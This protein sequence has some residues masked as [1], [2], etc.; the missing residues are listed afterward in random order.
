MR[1]EFTARNVLDADDRAVGVGAQDNLA[2]FLFAL[3]TPL[4]AHSVGEFLP[5]RDRLGAHGTGGVHGILG[6]DRVNNFRDGDIELGQLIR[7]NPQAHGV[8]AGAENGDAG[9]AL[10]PGHLVVDVDI[11]VVGQENVI[12][13]PVR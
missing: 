9:D 2:K 8:L 13:S 12:V 1:T 4:R 11:G 7:R 3:Q 10:D 6:A 5:L